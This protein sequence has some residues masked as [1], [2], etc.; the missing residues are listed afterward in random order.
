MAM[1]TLVS[2]HLIVILREAD[3]KGSL[4]LREWYRPARNIL[5]GL[6]KELSF[7]TLTFD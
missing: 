7:N 1:A 2:T 4:S 6:K 5:L 3:L